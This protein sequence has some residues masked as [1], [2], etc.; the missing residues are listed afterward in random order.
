MVL[1][2]IGMLPGCGLRQPAGPP[3]LA[4][5]LAADLGQ[6]EQRPGGAP[7]VVAPVD[8]AGETRL[9]IATPGQSRLTWE[10][11]FPDGAMLQ[12][13]VAL[14]PDAWSMNGDGVLFRIGVSD[15]RIHED[16]VTRLVNPHGQPEDRRWIR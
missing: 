9:A 2:A 12:V 16:V 14:K 6:A 15:G 1:V 4:R 3:S 5:D 7:F 10:Q 11:Y 13:A 8:V